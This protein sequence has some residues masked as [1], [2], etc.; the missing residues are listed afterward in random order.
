MIDWFTVGA[1]VVNFLVLVALLK[2]FLYGPVIRAMDEREESIRARLREADEKREQAEQEAADYR[3]K[4]AELDELR[5]Q[6]LEEARRDAERERRE[7]LR[8]AREEADALARRWRAEV[9]REQASFLSD[10][11]RGVGGQSV[12]IARR[13]L[14]DLADVPLERQLTAAFL[15]RVGE[16]GDEDKA[17]LADALRDNGGAAVVRTAFD[18]DPEDRERIRKALGSVVEDRVEVTFER[19]DD[20]VC[21][22]EWVAGGRKLGWTLDGYLDEVAA[23]IEEVLSRAGGNREEDG[24]ADDNHD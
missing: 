1:Q 2:R 9:E 3:A 23:E 22:I 21:G 8:R 11:R 10:L 15:N 12:A 13:A 17:T 18:P 6:A 7:R 20:L 5:E 14:G 24:R 4:Q 19:S 16:L